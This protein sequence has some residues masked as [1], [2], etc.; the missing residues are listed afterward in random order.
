MHPPRRR[1]NPLLGRQLRRAARR[2]RRPLHGGERRRMAQ[3]RDSPGERRNRLLGRQTRTRR[4]ARSVDVAV[5][6]QFACAVRESDS[7]LE[8]WGTN[9]FGRSVL[10]YGQAN[11]PEGEFTSVSAGYLHA[12]GLRTTG[13]ITCWGATTSDAPTRLRGVFTQVSSGTTHSC[14]LRENG[15]VECWGLNNFGQF[16]APSG[17]FTQISAGAWH[18]VRTARIRRNRV[19]GR[20]PLRPVQ[21]PIRGAI[22]P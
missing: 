17:V 15:A 21:R 18:S 12:C 8:C 7:E 4:Q 13:E 20:R 11:P 19:L 6:W 16:N 3:L 22:S 14:A 10:D 2:P 9:S 1:P 5:G